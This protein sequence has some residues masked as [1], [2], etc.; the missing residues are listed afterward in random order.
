MLS[1]SLRKAVGEEAYKAIKER[2]ALPPRIEGMKEVSMSFPEYFHPDL[3]DPV[4]AKS[5]FAALLDS[6]PDF[7]DRSLLTLFYGKDVP[8]EEKSA[9]EASALEKNDFLEVYPF[10]GNQE[11]YCVLALLE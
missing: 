3:D 2:Y 6:V 10:F 11:I 5:A 7:E 4:Y 8:E 9:I 1:G